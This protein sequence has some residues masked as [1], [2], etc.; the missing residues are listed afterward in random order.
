MRLQ[1][2]VFA[3]AALAICFSASTRMVLAQE[4]E[5]AVGSDT[6]KQVIVNNYY[7][8]GYPYP[9]YPVYP[10]YPP[11]YGYYYPRVFVG[12]SVAVPFHHRVFVNRFHRFRGHGFGRTFGHFRSP[13]MRMGTGRGR[14]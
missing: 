5:N 8:G 1:S 2:F 9:N 4:E 3:L 11:F 13:G 12:F 10:A 6:T 7:Y 14:Y